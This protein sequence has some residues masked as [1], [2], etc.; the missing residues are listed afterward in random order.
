LP[1]PTPADPSALT[2]EKIGEVIK[3]GID[4]LYGQ[5]DPKTHMVTHGG[6]ADANA[7]D[8][9]YQAGLDALCVYSLMQ[10]SLATG[11]SDPRVMLKGPNMRSM[12]AA[13]EAANLNG[14]GHATYAH[15]LRATALAL[16]VANLHLPEG[17][18]AKPNEDV[19]ELQKASA[20]LQEDTLY[21]L[22]ACDGGAYTYVKPKDAPRD[23]KALLQSYKLLRPNNLPLAVGGWDNSNSQYGLLGVWSAVDSEIGIEIPI[24]YW[25]LV[26]N[27]WEKSQLH[28]GGWGY[29][30]G[31]EGPG[32]GSATLTMT[33]AGLASEFVAHE[34][35]EPVQMGDKPGRIPFSPAIRNGLDWFEKGDNCITGA[36]GNGYALYG[37]ERVGLASGFKFFGQHDWYRELATHIVA[38]QL[39]DGSLPGGYGGP[40]NSAYS[41]L[42]LSRG[43]HPILMN[44]LRFDTDGNKGIGYWLNRPQ[45]ASNLARFVGHQL[46]NPLNFQVINVDTDWT[47]WLDSPILE[48][49]SHK[50]V[51]FNTDQVDKIR[52]FVEAGGMLFVQADGDSPEFNRAV[53]RLARELFPKYEFVPVPADH[54][55]YGIDSGVYKLPPRPDLKMINNGSRILMLWSPRDISKYWQARDVVRHK[56]D[57]EFGANMFVYAAGK[58]NLRNRLDSPYVAPAK[59]PPVA[60][61]KLA[62]LDYAGNADPE[63]GAWRRYANLFQEQTGTK[64]EVTNI[65]LS[66]LTPGEAPVAHL[67]GTAKYLFSPAETAAIKAYVEAGG[68]LLIDQCGGTGQFDQSTNLMLGKAFPGIVP[69]TLSPLHPMLAGGL[70]GT[71]DLSHYNQTR[72]RRAAVARGL[73][74][75]SALE[76]LAAGKGHVIFT[77]LDITSGLLSTATGGILGFDSNYCETL[78]KNIIFWSVDGQTDK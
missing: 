30:K 33:C 2:D 11:D 23:F 39:P 16:F 40:I 76:I 22:T 8:L 66:A 5:F 37:V 3:K 38:A 42:F 36:P 78:V 34:Y 20:V 67:T 50:E 26:N 72:F 45:D 59:A 28:D 41:L 60:T 46:E 1:R 74:H 25:A 9:S 73:G 12:I 54:P 17:K 48:I 49:A 44:K 35:L 29:S 61:I 4:Y 56:F 27:H 32:G 19:A 6:A 10:C 53:P 21:G 62:R 55:M 71:E 13:L 75:G 63:P 57:F 18:D 43:R 24:E 7:M 51:K 70:P 68:M 15:G 69:Q 47:Q 14:G 52:N 58:R 77:P 65:K 64:L 31:N